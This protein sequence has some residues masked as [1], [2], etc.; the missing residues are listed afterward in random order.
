[1]KKKKILIISDH[2]LSPSGV[3]VQSNLL[4]RGLIKTGK[5]SF[6]QLGAAV[7]HYDLRTVKISDDFY[8]KPIEGFGNP[9]LIRSILLNEKP[10]AI[11]I[12]SDPRFFEYLFEIEDE[13]HQICPIIWWHVW[14]NYP[15]PDFNKWMYDSVDVINC[16]SY[17]TFNLLENK[18]KKE[19][20]NYIPHSYPNDMFYKLDKS[21][22]KSLKTQS[23]GEDHKDSFVCLWVNRNTRRKR[24]I[25]LLKSWSLF[26]DKV[27][28]EEKNKCLLIMHTDHLDKQGSNIEKNIKKYKLEKSVIISSQKVETDF[29]NNLYNISDFTLNIS[30][31]EGF[32][33]TTLESMMAGTPIIATKTGGLIRQ[34]IDYSDSSENGIPIEIDLITLAGNQKVHFI[35]ED[36]SSCE[37]IANKIF[38]G[39]SLNDKDKDILS[40][41]CVKYAKKEFNYKKCI[42][43]W[44]QTILNCINQYKVKNKIEVLTC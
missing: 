34:V 36:F 14:D 5:Y 1:M 20:L 18:I 10:D 6:I 19:K 22:K 31:N 35:N 8:I 13:V 29:L 4:I 28:K 41:K 40:K 37:N 33:L 15:Y 2:A 16:L 21:K 12:F 3:G 27:K 17:F 39:Y 42:K 44:D 24:P 7:K 43:I 11:I 25:D 26:L 30:S 32:G 23:L 38:E 9:N